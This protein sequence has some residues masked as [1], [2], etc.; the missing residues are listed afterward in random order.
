MIYVL[1]A[2]HLKE[3]ASEKF[4]EI[5]KANISAVRAEEGCLEYVPTVDVETNLPPQQL[6]P[7]V[8][9]IV[10]KWESVEALHKHLQAPHM[11]EYRNKTKD[12]VENTI[13]KVLTEA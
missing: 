6:D 7:T 9:T 11:L 5:F 2:V 12:L 1:A 10:E 4:L 3:G 8:V 13:L